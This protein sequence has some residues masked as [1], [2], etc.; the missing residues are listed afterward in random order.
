ML[1][2]LKVPGDFEVWLLFELRFQIREGYLA[3]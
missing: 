1:A 3:C 2:T